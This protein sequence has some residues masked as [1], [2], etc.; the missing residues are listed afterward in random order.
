VTT[1]PSDYKYRVIV[2][3]PAKY[4]PTYETPIRVA[5]GRHC[6]A[7]GCDVGDKPNPLRDKTWYCITK[8]EA[9]KLATK[10]RR[11]KLVGTRTRVVA[12]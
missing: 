6:E 1:A 2:T 10:V 4:F 7:G 11:L 12:F 3:Y 9:E 8:A 5:V